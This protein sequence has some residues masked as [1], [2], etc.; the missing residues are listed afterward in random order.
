MSVWRRARVVIF[1]L[2]LLLV[3]P[4]AASWA[5]AVEIP[6]ATDPANARIDVA[7]E[8]LL[9]E[10]G[11][12]WQQLLPY[13]DWIAIETYG[14]FVLI[15]TSPDALRYLRGHRVPLRLL[16]DPSLIYLKSGTLDTKLETYLDITHLSR[17]QSRPYLVTF[18]LP[19]GTR[20]QTQLNGAGVS[21]TEYVP[22]NSVISCLN[23]SSAERAAGL[24]FVSW[25]GEFPPHY[26][27]DP[28]LIGGSQDFPSYRLRIKAA[29][30]DNEAQFAQE[31]A[32]VGASVLGWHQSRQSVTFNVLATAG[33]LLKLA[34]IP[35]VLWITS[36][37]D[38]ELLDEKAVEIVGG[39]YGG[40]GSYV[41]SLGYTGSGI[42]VA[43]LDS[44]IYDGTA[45]ADHPDLISKVVDTVDYFNFQGQDFDDH[46]T[47][48][49]GIIAGDAD[50][51]GEG[52]CR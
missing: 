12:A 39:A 22:A 11:G 5:T 8:F 4:V 15:E 18:S 30:I 34:S 3:M 38:G 19:L 32:S 9:V 41:N 45:P 51:A 42:T 35:Q 44:G 1:G 2:T 25:M 36:V 48:V 26:K 50:A 29:C 43:V 10:N 6:V 21:V 16:P 28:E 20:H 31:L 17:E 46:G 52:R 27:I 47:P 23:R 49:A 7:K 13:D 14:R 24:P 40:I 33:I 37:P